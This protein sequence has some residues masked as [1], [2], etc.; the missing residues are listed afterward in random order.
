MSA[1]LV[2]LDTSFLIA[3]ENLDD[4]Y[5]RKAVGLERQLINAQTTL[6]LHQ[7]IVP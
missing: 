7:G 6:V 2:F 5:H 3:L 1:P 4:V